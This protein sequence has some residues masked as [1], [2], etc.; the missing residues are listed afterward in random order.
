MAWQPLG[1]SARVIWGYA[2]KRSVWVDRQRQDRRCNNGYF[3]T[4]NSVI[5]LRFI[6]IFFFLHQLGYR[7]TSMEL[8]LP[9]I[10]ISN[11]MDFTHKYKS[12]FLCLFSKCVYLCI[13]VQELHKININ[14]AW[15][16][17]LYLSFVSK[18]YILTLYQNSFVA[19]LA[20]RYGH[21]TEI[22]T[23]YKS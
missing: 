14:T 5:G 3:A 10:E 21:T 2:S 18:F 22:Y 1:N 11:W 17:N 6:F 12:I 9:V 4:M 13:L 23:N 7:S 8:R 20:F 19:I 16:S 15:I